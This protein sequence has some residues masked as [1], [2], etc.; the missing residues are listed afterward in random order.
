M[1]N[2]HETIA[3]LRA[4]IT[5]LRRENALLKDMALR[6]AL[7]GIY[8]RRMFDVRLEAEWSRAQRQA[9]QISILMID[10]DHFKRFNDQ[11]GHVAG[12]RLLHQLA[13]AWSCIK[14]RGNDLLTR[15]GGEEF[16]VILPDTTLV[17]ATKLADRLRMVAEAQGITVSIGIAAIK[18]TVNNDPR[19]LLAQADQALYTAKQSGRNRAVCYS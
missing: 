18:P 12:D 4:E 10:I 5:A 8:N 13:A 19:I 16:A 14:M 2:I 6:D 1:N 7:T 17:G 9:T 11:H 3:T 15:Y